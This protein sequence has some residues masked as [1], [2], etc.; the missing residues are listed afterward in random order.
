MP[1]TETADNVRRAILIEVIAAICN[2]GRAADVKKDQGIPKT[3]IIPNYQSSR[4]RRAW[5]QNS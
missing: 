5:W 1:A 2:R 4:L 3:M